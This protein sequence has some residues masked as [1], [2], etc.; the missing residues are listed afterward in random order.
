M[1]DHANR[2][3]MHEQYKRA[4]VCDMQLLRVHAQAQVQLQQV[5]C[6]L[7]NAQV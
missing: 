3:T 2:S 6:W 5:T 7:E 1:H 4:N